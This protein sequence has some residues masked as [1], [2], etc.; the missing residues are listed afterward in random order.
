MLKKESEWIQNILEKLQINSSTRILNFGSQTLKQL[1]YQPY[2]RNFILRINQYNAEIINLDIKEG[3][4]VDIVGN[5]LENSVANKLAGFKFDIILLNNVLEHV[6][7]IESICQRIESI[8]ASGGH[9]IFSGPYKYPKHL[10]PIDNMFRPEVKDVSSLFPKCRVIESE[11][12]KDITYFENL[13]SSPSNFISEVV[14]LLLPFYKYYKW[15]NIVLPKIKWLNKNFE[16]TC[17]LLKK[18][19]K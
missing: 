7:S 2:L 19:N 17:V 1:K 13:L 12:I 15:K 14:R 11:I 5:I 16:V 10:D 18:I 3:E 4:G 9:I 8:I 6:E